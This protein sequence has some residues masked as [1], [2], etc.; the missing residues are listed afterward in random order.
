LV[1]DSP[2]NVA[3]WTNDVFSETYYTSSMPLIRKDRWNG[4]TCVA[5][6]LHQMQKGKLSP[7]FVSA[8]LRS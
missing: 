8:W 2:G 7:A 5:R 6:R 4:N 3:E 1:L